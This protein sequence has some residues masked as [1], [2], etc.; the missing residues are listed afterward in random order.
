MKGTGSTIWIS[1]V[2]FT[3]IAIAASKSSGPGAGVGPAAGPEPNITRRSKSVAGTPRPKGRT[4]RT[5]EDVHSEPKVALAN[6]V[7]VLKPDFCE[8]QLLSEKFEKEDRQYR[9][10]D[11]SRHIVS[12]SD[13]PRISNA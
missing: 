10:L 1:L 8:A 2:I 4:G 7:L 12:N 5:M 3:L 11:T 13:Q 6:P 9:K